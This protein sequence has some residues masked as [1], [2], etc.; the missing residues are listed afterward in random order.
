MTMLRKKVKIDLN[1]LSANASF[2]YPLYS[3]S[4]EKIVDARV[5]LTSKMI[6]K[7]TNR[8]GN[9]V[10]YVDTG[11]RAIIPVY[12]MKIAYNTSKEIMNEISKTDKLSRTTYKEVEKLVGDIID[13]LNTAEI[14]AVNLMKELK[15]YDQY[16]YN[17]SVN[18]GVLSAIFAHKMGSFSQDEIRNL[19]I[20]AYLHDIGQKQIDRQLLNKEGKLNASEMQKMKRHPQLGY[21]ILNKIGNINPIVLQSVLLHHEKFNNRGYYQLPYQHLPIYPKIVSIS[22]VFDALTSPRPFRKHAMSPSISLKTILNSVGVHYDYELIE[23]FLNTMTLL[24]NDDKIFYSTN[25]ICELDTRELALIREPNRKDMLKP[26]VLVFC[27][28]FKKEG[29]TM[30]NFYNEPFEIELAEDTTRK[31]KKILNNQ[32]QIDQINRM[33]EERKII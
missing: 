12:R 23:N 4:G 13:D 32:T 26:N 2:I 22:D 24:L 25:D 7:I 17:H 5:V 15:G 14:E 31:M 29:K 20:G 8:Y 27:K 1:Y 3:E 19:T 28:F 30:V 11:E 21:E 18:V 6:E 9:I 10:Y 33:I 16:L